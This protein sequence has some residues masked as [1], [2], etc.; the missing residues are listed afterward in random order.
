MQFLKEHFTKQ[1][2]FS[3][4]CQTP[5]KT[6]KKDRSKLI[7]THKRV[8]LETNVLIL[9]LLILILLILAL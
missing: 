5:K 1:L 8:Q 3:S 6:K 2:L 4:K 7:L 9:L